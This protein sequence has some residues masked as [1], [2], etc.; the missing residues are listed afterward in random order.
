MYAAQESAAQLEAAPS[1][2]APGTQGPVFSEVELRQD[3]KRNVRCIHIVLAWSVASVVISLL[4]AIAAWLYFRCVVPMQ[5]SFTAVGLYVPS[6]LPLR[7]HTAHHRSGRI[8]SQNFKILSLTST[9]IVNASIVC[10]SNLTYYSFAG[11]H[12]AQGEKRALSV[13]S[14][15]GMIM[16]AAALKV[17]LRFSVG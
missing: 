1:E 17:S 9:A 13:F 6:A 5:V 11:L 7:A 4:G 15:H 8:S 16:L 12:D 3:L 14:G 10:K 2:S